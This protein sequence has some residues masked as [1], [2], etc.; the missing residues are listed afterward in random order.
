MVDKCT[1]RDEQH[2]TSKASRQE[3]ENE[4]K[5]S[6]SISTPTRRPTPNQ[7]ILEWTGRNGNGRWDKEEHEREHASKS[8]VRR[9]DATPKQDGY[10]QKSSQQ[11]KGGDP[12]DAKDQSKIWMSK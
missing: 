3:R 11:V 10:R 4:E 2:E 12:K 6:E 9:A 8:S 7:K 5:G 1:G